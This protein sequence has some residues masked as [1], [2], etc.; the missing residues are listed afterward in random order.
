MCSEDRSVPCVIRQLIRLPDHLWVY[1]SSSMFYMIIVYCSVCVTV[2]ETDGVS[3]C[4]G[5]GDRCCVVSVMC[6]NTT[7]NYSHQ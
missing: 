5:D 7:I 3:C 4:V 1:D 6:A 2:V